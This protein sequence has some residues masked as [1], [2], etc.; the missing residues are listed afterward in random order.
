MSN[1][2]TGALIVGQSGGP[3]AVINASLAG[4]VEAALARSQLTSVL[5]MLHGIEGALKD[6]LFDLAQEDPQVIRGLVGTPAAALG[7]CR[8]K[9]GLREYERILEVFKAHNVRY[10]IYIGGNDSMDTAHKVGQLAQES[11][12]EMRVMGVPKTI[13]NDLALTDHCPGFGSAARYVALATM[14]AG[15]DLA[16][17]ETFEDVSILETMGRH[18]GWLAA[19]SVLGKRDEHDPPHLVYLPER[20]FDEGKFLNDVDRVHRTVGHVMVVVSEGIQDASG[21]LIGAKQGPVQTDAFGHKTI[22]LG[23]GVCPYLQ[24]LLQRELGLKARFNRPGTLQRSCGMAASR[25]DLEEA[26]LVGRVAVEKAAAGESGFMVTLEREEGKEYRCTTGLARLEDVANAE[27]LM[28]QEFI[29]EAGNMPSQAFVN[30]A[31][32]LIGDP[33]PNYVRL[34][35]VQV[36]RRTAP[37]G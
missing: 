27:K 6:E 30:Y 1:K 29:N 4:I 20:T 5:G 26:Y 35:G 19:A 17:M 12:Y 24:D 13:D 16:S 36:P 33:L 31:L 18:A 22:A 11:G 32:P 2:L 25:V 14:D 3:T 21:E 28:P 15:R 37:W 9:L 23:Q 10:F 34:K 7:S 8:H